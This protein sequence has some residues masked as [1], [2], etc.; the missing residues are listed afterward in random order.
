M[1]SFQTLDSRLS[2]RSIPIFIFLID[3]HFCNRLELLNNSRFLVEFKG[4]VVD[5][6]VDDF[7]LY[8]GL[9]LRLIRVH[10]L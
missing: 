3:P 1:L 5:F 10:G 2:L 7:L 9:A 4:F 6:V 8:L